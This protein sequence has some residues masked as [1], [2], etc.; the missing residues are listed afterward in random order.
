MSVMVETDSLLSASAIKDDN[1]NYVEVGDFFRGMQA[2]AEEFT[3][4]FY[5]FYSE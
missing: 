4:Y 2:D 1:R 3:K 5:S